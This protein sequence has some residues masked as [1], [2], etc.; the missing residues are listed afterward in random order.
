MK[1]EMD[2]AYIETMDLRSD[3]KVIAMTIR[4][5]S[6]VNGQEVDGRRIE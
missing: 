3:L 5:L 2:L 1:L 4:A 6:R